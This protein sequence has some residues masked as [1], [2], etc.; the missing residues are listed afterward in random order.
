MRLGMFIDVT[1]SIL[2]AEKFYYT[3]YQSGSF[4]LVI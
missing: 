4:S 1:E 2:V 3:Q